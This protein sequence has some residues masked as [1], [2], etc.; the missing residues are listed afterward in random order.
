MLLTF[1]DNAQ[2]AISYNGMDEGFSLSE[3]LGSIGKGKYR[4]ITIQPFNLTSDPCLPKPKE[5]SDN[6]LWPIY[7][8]LLGCIISCL[9]QA[10]ASRLRS[11]ICNFFYPERATERAEFLHRS[12]KSGRQSRRNQL[13]EYY[14]FPFLHIIAPF[15]SIFYIFPPPRTY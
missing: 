9:M 15:S 6:V 13:R 1:R 5:T 10:Y 3:V 14:V 8:L 7:F 12:I 11:R 4:R 2:F